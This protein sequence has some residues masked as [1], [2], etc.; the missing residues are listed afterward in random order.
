M[1]Y[2]A[3]YD[4]TQKE[5]HAHSPSF[6]IFAYLRLQELVNIKGMKCIVLLQTVAFFMFSISLGTSYFVLILFS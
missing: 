1:R 3:A 5:C 6:S 4:I 2:I